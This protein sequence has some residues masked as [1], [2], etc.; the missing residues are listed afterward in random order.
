MI[1]LD[2]V[3]A[4]D[5]AVF[6]GRLALEGRGHVCGGPRNIVDFII[7]AHVV[8][9]QPPGIAAL[10]ALY[11]VTNDRLVESVDAELLGEGLRI[12]VLMHHVEDFFP[13][14]LFD[15]RIGA[16]LPSGVIL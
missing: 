5:C 1:K 11:L 10:E 16:R 3:A 13:D 7:G 15:D 9:V 6:S 14:D 12:T 8:R 4:G 2:D